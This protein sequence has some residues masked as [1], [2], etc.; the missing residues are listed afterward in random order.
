MG[1]FL[2]LIAFWF[3]IGVSVLAALLQGYRLDHRG[4]YSGMKPL[5]SG[6]CFWETIYS[7]S[8]SFFGLMFDLAVCNWRL[9]DLLAETTSHILGIWVYRESSGRSTSSV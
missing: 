3:I 1:I 2:S 8:I 6:V 5:V 9:R 4:R 7:I